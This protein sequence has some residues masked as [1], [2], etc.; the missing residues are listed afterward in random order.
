MLE[1]VVYMDEVSM[2]GWEGGRVVEEVRFVKR[3]SFSLNLM[4][5]EF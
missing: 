2:G 3:R 1:W 4:N 5:E